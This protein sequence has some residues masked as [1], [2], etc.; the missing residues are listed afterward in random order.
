MRGMG[1]RRW[2]KRFGGQAGSG[3]TLLCFPYAGSSASI[4]RQWSQLVPG[5]VDTVA[6]QL[7]GRADRFSETPYNRMDPLI[8]DL[9]SVCSPLLERPFAFYG[10][11]MG[12]R[13]AWALSHRLRERGLPLPSMLFV[14]ASAA[15]VTDDGTWLWEDH[16]DGLEGY[17][18]E[19]G[20]TPPE[21]LAESE[22][23]A[24]LLTTLGA[25]LTVLSTHGGALRTAQPLP[26]PIHAF[27]G[28]DDPEAPPERMAG[29]AAETSAGFDLD[30]LPC[31]HFFDAQ[32]E[33]R[34]CE[35]VGRLLAAHTV[36]GR[37][38]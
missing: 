36:S 35:R 21:V 11:S 32:S 25:D 7:P 31:G 38:A 37:G 12:A 20:G 33:S 26:V 17:V 18:R 27:A 28:M 14:A 19:M 6:V 24:S 10:T 4:Y 3:P 13:V 15:P 34:V 8:D 2:L 22:L 23:L 5:P 30:A 1:D 9:V 16:A 29:W